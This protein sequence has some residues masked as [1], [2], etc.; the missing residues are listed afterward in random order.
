[1]PFRLAILGRPNVGKSTLFNRLAGKRLAIVDDYAGV[2]RDWRLHPARLGDLKFDVIDTAGLLGFESDL[3]KGQLDQ[4]L[5]KVLGLADVALFLVDGRAGLLPDDQVLVRTLRKN[6]PNLPLL[7][8]V[9]KCE[10]TQSARD[11]SDFYKLG[12]GDPLLFSA[13]HGLGLAELFDALENL[14]KEQGWDRKEKQV[15]VQNRE[16]EVQENS[17]SS[18]SEDVEEDFDEENFQGDAGQEDGVIRPLKLAV[19]GRPNA[20]KSTLI[21]A[22]LGEERFLTGEE[23]G[24]TRDAISVDWSFEGRDV[25]LCDTAGM[26]RKSKVAPGLERL[27]VSDTLRAIRFSEVTVLVLDAQSPLDKQDLLIAEHVIREGRN[28]VIAFN[29]VDQPGAASIEGVR[30]RLKD[31]L[32]QVKGVPVIGISALKKKNLPKLMRQVLKQ[33]ALWNTRISTAVLNDWLRDVTTKHPPPIVGNRRL[34]LKYMTQIKT[35]PPTFVLFASKPVDLPDSYKRYLMN[36]LR[37][38]FDL[39]GVTLRLSLRKGA[40]PYENKKNA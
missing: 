11:A 19:V 3:L 9:N 40:N 14:S 6:Y 8:V 37:A 1:M 13:E 33:D 23:A 36:E 4:S 12:L 2:T 32:S 10:S 24:I 5:K 7:L 26:R 16:Q 30:E 34:K 20:G 39:P 35:R 29:K 27:S 38:E 18:S 17:A 28:L 22:L 21:N 15:Q 31:V 25:R